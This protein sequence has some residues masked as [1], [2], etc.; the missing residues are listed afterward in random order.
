MIKKIINFIKYILFGEDILS[1]ILFAIF[2]AIIILSIRFFYPYLFSVDVTASMQ[3]DN[4]DFSTYIPYNITE[5][6][7][8]NFPFNQGIN[9]GDILIVIPSD[10]LHVGDVI[11]YKSI[12]SDHMILHRLVDIYKNDSKI[13]YCAK[14]DNNPAPLYYEKECELTKDRI[15][16]KAVFRIP[17]LGIGRIFFQS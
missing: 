9:V 15:Y 4:F 2:I 1:F 3:H 13:Y 8:Q 6:D 12:I 5:R 11:L 7:F 17:L 16:G 10:N 14:G